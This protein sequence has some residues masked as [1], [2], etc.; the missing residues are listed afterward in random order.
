FRD[1]R[2]ELEGKGHRFRSTGDVEVVLRLWAEEGPECL[3]RLNG[4]FALAVWDGRR[5]ELSLARDRFGIKPLY[6]CRDHHGLAFASELRSL[7]AGGYPETPRIDE[8]QLR[9]Y[10][11]FGYLSP[12]GAPFKDVVSLPPATILT[13]GEEGHERLST[14]WSPP[15]P[16]EARSVPAQV[17]EDMRKVLEGAV[18]RQLVADVPVGV[19]LSGGLDSS[20]VSALAQRR[21]SG[22][23]RTFSVGFEGPDAISELPAAR[24]IAHYLGSD[25]H[26]LMMDPEEVARDLEQIIDGLDTPLADPTAIPTWYMSR[27]ARER[28]TVALSGEGADEIFGGYA[29]QRYDVALDRI[30][31]VG[32]K[33]LPATML[34]AGKKSS[35]RLARRLRMTPGLERQL[36][37]G[38][39]FSSDAIERLVETPTANEAAIHGPYAE[40]A[41]RWLDWADVDPVNGRLEADRCTFLPGDLLPKVDRMSMAHSLEV[42]VPYLDNEVVDLALALPGRF[43]QNL[44]RDKILLR[45]VASGLLPEAGSLRRKRGF[46]VPIGAW[47][48]GPLRPALTELLA[49][50]NVSGSGVLRAEEVSRL[51]DEHLAQGHDHGR[52]LWSLMVLSRW[53][54][55]GGRQ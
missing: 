26:E 24:E 3:Q 23:L 11:A 46:E 12:E 18:E 55:W 33:L 10:L 32:R 21:V 37:W 15:K 31:G 29:R 42:R 6:L 41:R 28:V 16:G 53:L 52:A 54:D 40:L 38:R 8:L 43:K 14:Y 34:L 30:G 36:D 20:T 45:E 22:P 13:V 1:L 7:R 2:R 25:H 5:R 49:P 19:F 44:R 51:V 39:L 48:R 27:L 47:L 35:T 50:T 4:M 9:H 17:V